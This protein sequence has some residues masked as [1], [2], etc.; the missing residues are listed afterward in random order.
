MYSNQ[1]AKQ[2]KKS[3]KKKES[4]HIDVT[5]YLE[6]DVFILCESDTHRFLISRDY[7]VTSKTVR[8]IGNGEQVIENSI[9]ANQIVN[10]HRAAMTSEYITRKITD[11]FRALNIKEKFK[12]WQ[13]YSQALQVQEEEHSSSIAQ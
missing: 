3:R 9:L 12:E 2:N 5:P 13:I 11:L 10:P 8:Y 4:P 1:M 6:T 7:L